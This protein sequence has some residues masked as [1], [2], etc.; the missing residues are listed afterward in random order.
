MEQWFLYLGQEL[1]LF[2][3][4]GERWS[5]TVRPVCSIRGGAVGEV[6]IDSG[7][8]L[9]SS[10]GFFQFCSRRPA[11]RLRTEKR[12]IKTLDD[13]GGDRQQDPVKQSHR[14]SLLQLTR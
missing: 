9:S 7:L 14:C 6:G 8:R 4:R 3:Q 13:Q 2:R 11:S 5:G 1:A 10:L 12:P